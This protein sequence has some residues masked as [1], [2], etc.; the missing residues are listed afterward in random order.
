MR[1]FFIFIFTL[2]FFA[3]PAFADEIC[4]ESVADCTKVEY[5]EVSYYETR[6]G[7]TTKLDLEEDIA[8][9]VDMRVREPLKHQINIVWVDYDSNS[10]TFAWVDMDAD[11][12]C[13]GAYNVIFGD[14]SVAVGE[15]WADTQPLYG[16]PLGC[17]TL[18]A[19]IESALNPVEA[20]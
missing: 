17:E 11:N 16:M 4:D 15:G 18:E 10:F 3:P 19:L 6:D 12:E 7:V 13:Q 5:P 14:V 20:G 1:Y 2:F 9:V 8:F